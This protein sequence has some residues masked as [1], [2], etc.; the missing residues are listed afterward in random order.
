MSEKTY[1]NVMLL[2]A[3]DWSPIAGCYGNDV[4]QTPRIDA[5]AREGVVFDHGFCTTPTCSASRATLL[6]GQYTHT[7]GHYGHCHSIHGFSTHEW[8]TSIPKDLRDAG[9]ATGLIGTS[10]VA[11]PSVYPFEYEP[12]VKAGDPKELAAHALKFLNENADRPFYLHVGYSHV[13]RHGDGFGNEEPFDDLPDTIYDPADVVVP[14]WLPDAPLVREDLAEY[15]RAITRFDAGVGLLLDALA[16]SGRADDTLVILTS[17]HGMPFPGA[18]ATSFES[19]H[20]CPL[21]IRK[22][23]AENPCIHSSALV[24]WIDIRPTVQDWAGV[25]PSEKLPG[26]SLVP[27]LGMTAPEGWDETFYSHCFHEVIDYNPYRVLRGRRYKFVQNLAAGLPYMLP[28]DLFRSK[29][30]RAVQEGDLEM[31]G[32]RPTARV[33]NHDREALYDLEADPMETTNRIDDADLKEIADGMRQ[34]LYA[35][36][37]AT[38]DPWLEVDF[39]EGRLP[40]SPGP[41]VR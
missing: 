2:I 13:H 26:R 30:W 17:D 7:N 31:M 16:E 35:F 21:I 27:I 38:R 32:K 39:Q 29:T 11:P 14:D 1:K 6:T 5:F 36:R 41:E 20:H 4:I 18:K 10:H 9:F 22:P 3:H 28:T 33:L 24:N 40:E 23:D 12:K 37:Q 8:L 34:R 19:G 15:Y 25:E